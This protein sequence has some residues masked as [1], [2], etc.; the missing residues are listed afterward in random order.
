MLE[1]LHTHVHVLASTS[2]RSHLVTCCCDEITGL[3]AQRLLRGGCD[4]DAERS[5]PAQEMLA[6]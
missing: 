2:G 1:M 5:C 4:T 3:E 6:C